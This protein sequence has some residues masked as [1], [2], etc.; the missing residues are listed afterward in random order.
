MADEKP[1][2]KQGSEL[3]RSAI[4]CAMGALFANVVF[5]VLSYAYYNSH[6]ISAPGVGE[7]VDTVARGNAREAFL[8]LSLIDAAVVFVAVRAPRYVGHGLATLLGLCSLAAAIG[9]FSKELPMVMPVTLLVVGVLSPTLAFFSWRRSR[10]AWA[11]LIALVAVFGGVDLFGAPK[12]R[13]LLGVG[14]WTAMIIPSLQF[15]ATLALGLI[16]ADY[17]AKA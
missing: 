1:K 7:F 9:A 14:L 5:F 3:V 11:F 4:L 10:A 16:R 12:V 8:V 2:P 13:A 17:R 6:K 15:A